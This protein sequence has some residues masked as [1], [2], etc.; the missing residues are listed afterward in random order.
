MGVKYTWPISKTILTSIISWFEPSRVLFVLHKLI[1]QMRMCSHPTGLDVWFLVGPFIYFH[2]SCVWTAKALARLSGYASSPEP[3]LVAYGISTIISW[4]GSF[5]NFSALILIISMLMKTYKKIKLQRQWHKTS[6]QYHQI[7]INFY[8][9]LSPADVSYRFS[10]S[11]C[12]SLPCKGHV[13]QS[14][15][16]DF[17][18]LKQLVPRVDVEQRRTQHGGSA[19]PMLAPF[20]QDTKVRHGG[21]LDGRFHFWKWNSTF[22]VYNVLALL[23]LGTD[24]KSIELVCLL[25][26]RFNEPVN[27]IKAMSNMVTSPT[28]TTSWAEL[29]I[30]WG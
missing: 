28:R 25:D 3:S 16:K 11:Q 23:I 13:L 9:H 19:D 22:L 27:T 4:A 30:L 10:I 24:K 2:S 21:V 17:S 1:F 26:L 6:N 8:A 14:Q 20:L 7:E 15:L 5:H 12:H 29:N 18:G